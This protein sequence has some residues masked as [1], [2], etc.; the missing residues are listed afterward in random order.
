MHSEAMVAIAVLRGRSNSA[1]PAAK[2]NPLRSLQHFANAEGGVIDAHRSQAFTVRA[3][4]SL[5]LHNRSSSAHAARSRQ[6]AAAGVGHGGR[7]A[8]DLYALGVAGHA[9]R[10]R[11]TRRT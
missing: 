9:T 7:F 3:F 10:E 11:H 6:C 1:S 5:R 8:A 4:A 2:D